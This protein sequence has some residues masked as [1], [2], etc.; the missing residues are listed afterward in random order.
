MKV[1]VLAIVVILVTHGL[2]K[3]IRFLFAGG[4]LTQPARNATYMY[5]QVKIVY[6]RMP[7]TQAR[8]MALFLNSSAA[9]SEMPDSLLRDLVSSHRDKPW[10]ELCLS[11]TWLWAELVGHVN[12]NTIPIS[13]RV[14]RSQKIRAQIDFANFAVDR[15]DRRYES[16]LRRMPQYQVM[17]IVSKAEAPSP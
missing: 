1:L 9:R 16:M 13:L 8:F 15:G 6:D 12:T 10:A 4:S 17:L 5:R 3:F 2:E 7:E 14:S 11:Y